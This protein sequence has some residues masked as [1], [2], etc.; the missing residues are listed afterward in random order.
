MVISQDISNQIED[1]KNEIKEMK[2]QM[3][4][5]DEIL[6]SDEFES[7]VKSFDRKNLVN[8]DEALDKLGIDLN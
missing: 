7:Y 1:L 2:S 5:R 6:N 8:F 3:V 4:S